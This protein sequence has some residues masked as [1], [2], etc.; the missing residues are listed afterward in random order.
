MSPVTRPQR[1]VPVVPVH[2]VG[3]LALLPGSAFSYKERWQEMANDLPTGSVLIVLPEGNVAQKTLLL[4]VARVVAAAGHQVRVVPEAE[5]TRRGHAVQ[6]RLP[7][8][9]LEAGKTGRG[10]G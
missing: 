6:E 4:G 7:L 5:M 9:V 1:T 8:P 2:H 10:H 3:N